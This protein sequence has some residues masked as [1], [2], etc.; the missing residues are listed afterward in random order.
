MRVLVSI[1]L[2]AGVLLSL[3][4]LAPVAANGRSPVEG[5]QA[6]E[7]RWVPSFSIGS[8][9]VFENQDGFNNSFEVDN[10]TSVVGPLQGVVTGSDLLVEPFVGPGLE[11]MTPA[12][13]IPTRPRFFLGGEFLPIFSNDHEVAL[14]GDPGCVRGPRV[15]AN[16]EP[17]PCVSEL[18]AP[19]TFTFT[20]DAAQGQGV[21]TTTTF[22]LLQWG[23]NFGVAFPARIYRRQLRIKPSFAWV[24]Y[25]VESTGLVVDATCMPTNRCT[26]TQNPPNTGPIVPGFVRETILSASAT[27]TFNAIGPGL[28][29]ELDVAR[30]N[31]W[32]GVSLFMGARAYHTLGNR[33]IEYSA[34]NT[35]NDTLGNDT[36]FA[37][38]KVDIAPWMYRGHVGI[39]FQWLGLPD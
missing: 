19:R 34:S 28:D 8:G 2:T 4:L 17:E 36:A 22:D 39:R 27:G 25:K 6:G 20:E 5:G 10:V 38:W 1:F 3:Q 30:F 32:L 29:I 9:L 21:S 37:N 33:T 7:D 31:N 35:Y 12:L 14:K 16:G 15:D 18:T 23:A 26:P 24:N 13:P 11:L